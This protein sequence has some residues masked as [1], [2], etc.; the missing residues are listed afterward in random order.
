MYEFIYYRYS[1]RCLLNKFPDSKKYKMSG[2][3][4]NS[5]QKPILLFMKHLL[6][7]SKAG[8]L[9]IDATSGTGTTAVITLQLKRSSKCESQAMKSK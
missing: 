7:W 2:K 9:V 6:C 1:T 3:L 4:L 8:D 5:H